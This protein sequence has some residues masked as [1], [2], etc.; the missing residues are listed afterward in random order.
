MK[1]TF[2]LLFCYFYAFLIYGQSTFAEVREYQN[3]FHFFGGYMMTSFRNPHFS[4]MKQQGAFEPKFG[5][6]LGGR[7]ITY[8]LILDAAFTFTDFKVDQSAWQMPTEVTARMY[9]GEVSASLALLPKVKWLCP[10]AGLGYQYGYLGAFHHDPKILADDKASYVSTSNPIWRA[11][12]QFI[13]PAVAF[14]VDYKQAFDSETA[15]TQI[16]FTFAYRM[17]ITPQ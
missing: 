9:G 10:Y 13:L 5:L 2:L 8:P 4:A 15:F 11:G 3:G 7:G 17:G 14:G 16:A 6:T 12:M 1:K